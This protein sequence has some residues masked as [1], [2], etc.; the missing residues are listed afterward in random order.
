MR[1][2]VCICIC[3]SL[4]TGA[5]F[6][7]E[8]VPTPPGGGQGVTTSAEHLALPGGGPIRLAE[9]PL[10]LPDKAA[11]GEK[12]GGVPIVIDT[13]SVLL[14]CSVDVASDGT[15]YAAGADQTTADGWSIR[16]HRSSDGGDTWELWGELFVPGSSDGFSYP[17][18]KVAEGSSDMCFVVYERNLPGV[19][20]NNIC[21][22]SSPLTA[23]T[24]D[25][26]TEVTVM[27]QT[28]VDFG[29]PRLFIDD[30]AFSPTTCTW[31]PR[32]TTASA[33]TSGSCVASTRASSSRASTRSP[34]CRRTTAAT[35]DP[36]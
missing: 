2:A 10:R 22:V 7:R 16:V 11:A 33:W 13:R 23:A 21:M 8:F 15:I 12:A 30:D 14:H 31:S 29:R 32:A 18:L 28:G 19:T 1:I 24:A 26:S 35:T 20:D 6:A 25:F 36:T 9:K 5:A 3:L 34:P 27:S 17:C 4:L